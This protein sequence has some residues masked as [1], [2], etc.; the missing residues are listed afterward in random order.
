MPEFETMLREALHAAVPS[1]LEQP[2]MAEGAKAYAVRV[3]RL[4][5]VSAAVVAAVV[6][7]IASVISTGMFRDRAVAPA[8]PQTNYRNPCTEPI[9]VTPLR[10]APVAPASGRYQHV[11]VCALTGSGSVW[12]GSLPPDDS[13][14]TPE[15]IDSLTWDL[16]D[17]GADCGG[18]PVGRAFTVNVMGWDGKAAAYLNTD[19]RCGGWDFLD[20]YYVALAEQRWQLDTT[21]QDPFLGCRSLFAQAPPPSTVR[22]PKGTVLSQATLC[23]HP[24]PRSVREAPVPRW[25][26]RGVIETADLARL[27]ADLAAHGS[28]SGRPQ[29]GC[30]GTSADRVYIIRAKTSRGEEIELRMSPT[31]STTWMVNQSQ[32]ETLQLR[33]S[34]VDA[35]S[36]PIEDIWSR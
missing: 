12:P 31:C 33:R 8:K 7:L 22:V 28:V 16:R 1:D 14:D 5:V 4:R 30:G 34:T 10:T 9:A 13:V 24:L 21:L 27:N 32:A 18:L 17:G 15:A 29:E 19:L 36:P 25:P 11:L 26:V 3:R 2:G 20:R 23:A 35:L 6:V